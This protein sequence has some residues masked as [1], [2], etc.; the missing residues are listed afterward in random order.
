MILEISNMVALLLQSKL[1]W[2]LVHSSLQ[3]SSFNINQWNDIN[4]I[5]INWHIWEVV[6]NCL[7]Q[8]FCALKWFHL[9]I[10]GSSNGCIKTRLNDGRIK[11]MSHV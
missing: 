4:S 7:G 8:T 11:V 3:L 1:C 10:M 9:S 5:W 6:I 2:K